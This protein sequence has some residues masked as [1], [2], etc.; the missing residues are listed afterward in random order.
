MTS[1]ADHSINSE[2]TVMVVSPE[3]PS[4]SATVRG[5]VEIGHEVNPEAEDKREERRPDVV[6]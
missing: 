2:P 1:S 5:P 3:A 4:T 6:V